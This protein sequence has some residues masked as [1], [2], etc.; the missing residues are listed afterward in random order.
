MSSSGAKIEQV[1][2]PIIKDLGTLNSG[3][4]SW[5][6][7]GK[8]HLILSRCPVG[9]GAQGGGMSGDTFGYL[10]LFL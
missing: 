2:L 1:C 9:A 4:L 5:N 7:M 10:V 6:A 8:S 3:F